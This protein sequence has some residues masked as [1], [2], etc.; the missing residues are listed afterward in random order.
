MLF[1]IL[2]SGFYYP[3]NGMPLVPL[4][5]GNLVPLTYFVRMSRALFLKGVG[6]GF[7]WTDAL[8][9]AI[10]TVVVIVVASKRFKMRLD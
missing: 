7:F 10:Y 6:L 5:I 2:L 3:R 1:G 9:L 4:L 8:A